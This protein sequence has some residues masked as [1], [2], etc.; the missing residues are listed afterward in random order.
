MG[1]R[2]LLKW[3]GKSMPW[4]EE[5]WT[6]ADSHSMDE[7]DIYLP[8]RRGIRPSRTRGFRGASIEEIDQISIADNAAN[9]L[10]Q[11]IQNLVQHTMDQHPNADRISFQIIL[12]GQPAEEF[13][14]NMGEQ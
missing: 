1:E 2:E 9:S 10:M 3:N 6:S 7:E 8:R 12:P 4:N 11:R 13:A 5:F 14:L